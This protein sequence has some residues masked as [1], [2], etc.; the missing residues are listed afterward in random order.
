MEFTFSKV[1]LKGWT[2]VSVIV[3]SQEFATRELALG[4]W[5]KFRVAAV[6]IN[7]SRGFEETLQA[8]KLDQ[9]PK[10]PSPPFNLTQTDLRTSKN[11]VSRYQAIIHWLEPRR[12]DLPI[13]KYKI[14]WTVRMQ[15]KQRFRQSNGR[16]EKKTIPGERRQLLLEDLHPHTIYLVQVQAITMYGEEKIRSEKAHLFLSTFHGDA[17][18]SKR[19]K[20]DPMIKQTLNG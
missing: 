3:N 8:F 10:H 2:H 19:M 12:S 14:T 5:Y 6:N 20:V 7:G 16:E 15:G 18:Q 17:F 9:D 11:K 13:D 1:L 4:R